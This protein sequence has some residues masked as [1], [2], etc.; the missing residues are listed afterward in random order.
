VPVTVIAG[1]ADRLLPSVEEAARLEKLIPGCRRMV[2]E[3]HGHAPL[4]D[5]RV[6]ISEII[7]SDPALKGVS[8]PTEVTDGA[9]KG[10][11]EG[12]EEGDM[13]SLLSGVYAK[14]WV[15]DFVEPDETMME[16]GTKTIDFLLKSVSPVFFS[17]KEDGTSVSG[18]SA[19]PDSD[20]SR[21]IVFV[22][23][24]QLL[25]LDLGVIV[26]RLFSEKGILARGLAHPV[27]FLGQ[28]T[29]RALDGV[30]DGVVKQSEQINRKSQTAVSSR[31]AGGG[32]EGGKDAN[33][34]QTFFAKF[35]AVPVSPRN[36]YRLLKRGD[37]VLLF[38]GGV[39]EAYHKK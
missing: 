38:P 8:F 10:G 35:G 21:P 22:G 36:M 28:T 15:N 6:D 23:N 31:G 29:P 26:E 5:G 16:E 17:T 7:K 12:N 1:S 27:V 39:S 3:G 18:L 32:E 34:M 24:H 4:F 2:L 25:A 13:A 33:G 30:V 37:N 20:R 14:D 19:V 11:G 9:K